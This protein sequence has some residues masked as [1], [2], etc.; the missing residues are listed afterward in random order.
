M[1]RQGPPRMICLVPGL[2]VPG[3]MGFLLELC[4]SIKHTRKAVEAGHLLRVD[5]HPP[6]LQLECQDP[7]QV[8]EE[9]RKRRL[10]VYRGKTHLTI[11]DGI[12]KVRIYLLYREKNPRE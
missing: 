7:D 9:A 11:T 4:E 6:Y 8:V 2:A 3:Y 5:Y 10:R 12:Y 1:R